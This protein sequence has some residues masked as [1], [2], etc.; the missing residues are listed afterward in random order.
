MG[1][2]IASVAARHIVCARLH[3]SAAV[4]DDFRAMIFALII[5]DDSA[6]APLLRATQRLLL[7]WPPL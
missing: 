7:V 1:D 6:F 5:I 2:V 4:E 3:R